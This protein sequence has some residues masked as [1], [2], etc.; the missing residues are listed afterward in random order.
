M[1]VSREAKSDTLVLLNIQAEQ[2]ELDEIKQHVLRRLAPGIKAPGFRPGKA[3][4]NIVEK[5]VGPQ[6][7][8]Q[9]FLDDAANALYN[10]AIKNERLRPV[11]NPTVN[12]KKF[13]PF[14]ALEMEVEVE[15]IGKIDLPNYKDL[16]V[17]KPV[18]QVTAADVNDVIENLRVRMAEK[19]EVER[20][21]KKGDEVWIDF[22]GKDSQGKPVSGASGKDYPLLL[23]SNTFIPGFEDNLIG[24]KKGDKKTFKLNF[25]KD[26]GLQALQGKEVT[27]EAEAVKVQELN[28]PA[29]D[30]ALAA[31]AGPFKTLAELKKDV[32]QQLTSE[33]QNQAKQAY[34][35]ALVKALADNTVVTIPD[36]LVEDQVLHME[37]EEKR[38]LVYRGQTWQE[39]LDMEGINEEE[40]RARHKPDAVLRVKAG[41]ALS[42]IAEL[43]KIFVTPEELEIRLDALRQQYSDPQMQAELAKPENQREITNQL[44]TEKTINRLVE[45]NAH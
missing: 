3:P 22:E 25:P 31:K 13:V 1:K 23:G 5:Q 17:E 40:H 11:G 14:T 38:N 19:Q 4:L 43:E 26:Y 45:L 28:K 20:A 8:Q 6:V 18:A 35:N 39:H 24:V 2:S 21:A 16:K 41:L 33:R 32:K 34:D 9:E 42:E 44:M 12:L 10:R 7:M 36:S 29:A 15:A 27:F 30:D 37:E